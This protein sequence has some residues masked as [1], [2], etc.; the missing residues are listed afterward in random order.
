MRRTLIASCAALV[1]GV[2]GYSIYWLVTAE[3]LRSGVERWAAS[4]QAEGRDLRWT[5]VASEGF[6]FSFRLR[7]TG[8]LLDGTRP[9][10][11]AAATPV[12]LGEARP[13]NLQQ[14]Q[15]SAP[16][17]AQLGMPVE[18]TTLAAATL[19]GT[20]DLGMPEGTSVTLTAHDVAASGS[21]PLR[22]AEAVL[23]LTL[24][25]RPPAGHRDADFEAA[26]HLEKMTLPRS[27]PPLGDT[28][29]ALS[30]AGTVKGVLPQGPLRQSLASWRE[31]GG[32]LELQDGSLHW[33]ALALAAT[34]TLA[35]DDALQPIGALTATV[36]DQ[37]AVLDAAAAQG[38]LRA[39]DANL[40]KI[41]LGLMAKPGADGKQRLTVP[42][43]LQNRRLY[44]GPAQIATL[45]R[46]TWE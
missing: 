29:D 27:L 46:F 40:A 21:A 25:P 2:A 36:V 9:L 37:D 17:G 13:W 8:V 31:D 6:P 42:L 45:P 14:W 23:H 28:V 35:L 43:S 41:V 30:L 44:L 10:P 20:L 11:F 39:S 7:V 18:G 5:A 24:P 16:E 15:V 34:G 22:I 19:D 38:T 12:L 26:L 3:R 1:L 32:T 33:G 4:R